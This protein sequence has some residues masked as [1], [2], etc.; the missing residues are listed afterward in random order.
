MR[1]VIVVAEHPSL[2]VGFASAAV[3][4][5]VQLHDRG[6][7]VRYLGFD[8]AA[9]A[10]DDWAF[11]VED[12]GTV[13]VVADRLADL[14]DPAAP[15]PLVLFLGRA[16]ELLTI[17]ERL[18]AAGRRAAVDLTFHASTDHTPAPAAT[19]R[20]AA[21]VDRIVPITAFAATALA[22]VGIGSSLTA[23]I[24]HGV[25]PDRFRPL[26][27]TVR[28]AV[29]RDL[30]LG[31][32]FVVG[33][34][35]RNSRHKRPDLAL[36]TFAHLA[37]GTYATCPDARC[38]HLTVAELGPDL[39]FTAPAA[40]RRCGR[41]G[42]RPGRPHPDAALL[43]HTDL[44]TATERRASGGFDLE[45]LARR[46]GVSGRVVF[47]RSIAVGQGVPVE[48][49]VARMAAM[50]VHLLL[51]EGGGWEMTV[52]ET[53]A[54]GVP[55][56]VT[57]HA[58]PGTYAAPFSRLVPVA[59]QVIQPWGVEGVADLDAATTALVDLARPE[60]RA[61]LAAAGPQVASAHSWRRVGDRWHDLLSGIAA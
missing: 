25:D 4:I 50:D 30:H 13:D 34:V 41:P 21:A 2:T 61:A 47:D 9:T 12:C 32:G 39:S 1:R 23:P 22:A 44:S 43:M 6:W 15:R 17:D 28:D 51:S 14:V 49:L 45:L 46:L 48:E 57:D 54:C 19:A 37:L 33:Y 27:A 35:G 26:P 16:L 40:C 11:P 20:L 59:N 56:I 8:G 7:T 55:N 52:L 3:N 5:A 38:G 53:A 58:G 31:D 29:R 24:T 10:G 18:R 60:A 36:R 42:G